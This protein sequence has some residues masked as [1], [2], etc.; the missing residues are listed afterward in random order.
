[1]NIFKIL[2]ELTKQGA[3]TESKQ[4]LLENGTDRLA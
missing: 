1:M 3:E 2:Q 4:M